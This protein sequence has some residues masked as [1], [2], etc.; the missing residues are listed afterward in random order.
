M[1]GQMRGLLNPLHDEVPVRFKNRFAMAS[2]LARGYGAGL[3]ASLRPLHHRGHRNAKP[4]GY[5]STA[6]PGRY[7][8]NNPFAQII[9]KWS[10][11]LMLAS[12]PASILN[13][14]R[15][16]LGIPKSIQLRDETL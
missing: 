5:R 13:P 4:G 15:D 1:Q 11:H 16:L 9:G 8:C 12:I 6:I 3:P 2:H 14:T 7:R 10:S